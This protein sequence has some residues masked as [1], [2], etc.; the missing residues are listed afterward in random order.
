MKFSK[1]GRVVTA[2]FLYRKTSWL[3]VAFGENWRGKANRY[4][5]VKYPPKVLFIQNLISVLWSRTRKFLSFRA[6]GL[7]K[8]RTPTTE[9]AD[10]A[11]PSGWAPRNRQECQW[12]VLMRKFLIPIAVAFGYISVSGASPSAPSTPGVPARKPLENIQAI[13]SLS[14]AEANKELR[15]AFKATVTNFRADEGNLFVQDGGAGLFVKAAAKNKLVPGDRVQ[16]EGTTASVYGPYVNSTEIAVVSHG[17][18]PKP[19]PA[20][21]D[22][23]IR[24]RFDMLQV[25][26]RGV[27]Q[28]ADLNAPTAAHTPG[29][30]LRVLLDG[31]YVDALVSS[32]DEKALSD[33][34]DAEVEITGVAGGKFDGKR[35]LTGIVLHVARLEDIKIVKPAAV[36]PWALPATPMDQVLS[37]YHVKNLTK[38]IRVVGTVTYFEPGTGLVLE[39]G[40]KSIW[41]KTDSISPMR[42]GDRAEAT[43]F[44]AV[45]NGSL[46]LYGSAIQDDGVQAPVRPETATWQQL[47]ASRHI[48]DLVTLE[49]RVQMEAREASQDE[50]V[51]VSG[52]QMFSAIFPHGSAA[53]GLS[54]MRNVPVGSW[55][56]VTGICA[57]DNANPYGHDVAFKILLRTPDDLVILK[58]P[59]WFT[60]Q[61]LGAVVVLLLL[62]MLLVGGRAW[63]IDRRMRAE[64]A[65][66]GYLGN[67]RG[68][69]LEDINHARPLPGILERITELGSASLKGAPCWCETTDGLNLGNRPTE[70]TASGLRIVEHAIASRS[71]ASVGSIF[72]AFD[73]R[74]EPKAEEGKA[75]AA[76][77]E[78]ATLA[79]ET[80][81]LYTDLVHRSE[82][83]MLTDIKNRFAFEKHIDC[84]LDEAYGNGSIFGLIYIDLDEF[85]Q[86]NDKF[87]H[88][89]GD[90]YIQQ[91][92]LRMKRQLRPEDM[93]SRL[94]GDEFAVLVPVVQSRA[95]VEEIALRLECCFDD[96]FTVEGFTVRG[97]ASVGI[98]L[99]PEDATTKDALLDTADTAMYA[100]KNRRKSKGRAQALDEETELA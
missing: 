24:R 77:A 36:S 37:V 81:R 75:L 15:V 44:P 19:V 23:L 73:A 55:I 26:A 41:I 16:I 56:R 46:M 12:I 4:G 42:V 28:S 62:A 95:D 97:S 69:I 89:V 90:Q 82:F 8:N 66:L 79:I 61:H 40:A 22:E 47:A 65:A 57:M 38:R 13:R 52:G 74:T 88:H 91:A 35:Q 45:S 29:I 87:G 25:T 14:D 58:A 60:V 18:P 50:Y 86:V 67:R 100:A 96:P 92:A 33:L 20:S 51:L 99:F 78:L 53:G 48:F 59:S 84:L 1:R 83:D 2:L 64:I 30:T 43:G 7:H 9:A 72:A 63:F 94:G 68:A 5:E 39:N 76:S 31:G 85:K 27:V 98:S 80:A 10:K 21:W 70:S 11:E 71:G 3:R 49:G 6:E 54:P 93:L 34:L 32:N 17:A